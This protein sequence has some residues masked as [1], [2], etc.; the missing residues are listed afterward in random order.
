[1]AEQAHVHLIVSNPCFEVWYLLHGGYSTRPYRCYD[2]LRPRLR[3]VIPDY[4]KADRVFQ[5]LKARQEQALANARRL[6]QHCRETGADNPS[7]DVHELVHYLCV[8]AGAGAAPLAT[9]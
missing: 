2:E 9:G 5:R 3:E 7:T 1:M 4:D 8:L 6:A